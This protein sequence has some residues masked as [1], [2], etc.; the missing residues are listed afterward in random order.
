MLKRLVSKYWP[1]IAFL[2]FIGAI[3]GM[4]RYAEHRKAEN[5]ENTQASSPQGTVTPNDASKSTENADKAKHRP[6]FIDTFA[7]P[8]GA[9]VWALFLTLIVI[10][11]QS[12]ETR[13]AA[14]ATVASVEAVDRQADVMEKTLVLQFRPKIIVRC[15]DVHTS[16]V[17]RIGEL[18]VGILDFTV[19]NTGGSGAKVLTCEVEV[20]AFITP[21]SPMFC[22]SH[23]FPSF[24][25][26]PGESTPHW[27]ELRG[28]VN[29]AI[30]LVDSL[31]PGTIGR[32]Q[33]KHIYFVGVI[34][35][36][37]RIGIRRSM[38]FSRRYNADL[39]RFIEVPDPDREYSD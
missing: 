5:Q 7:W 17:A 22:H 28:D 1:M 11:W 31:H 26:K 15:G 25:L 4:S 29:E 18:P 33:A 12:A 24:E 14:Q 16:N 39:K 21:P 13:A 10:A 37:D 3:L 23:Q 2:L 32:S 36:E 9:T 19:A 35:Y 20:L 34:W 30:R 38:A 8:E 27:A 6:D